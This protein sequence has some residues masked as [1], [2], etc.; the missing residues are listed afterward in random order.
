MRITTDL[1]ESLRKGFSKRF[2]DA[3][4]A[5]TP[6]YEQFASVMPSNTKTNVHGFID[7]IPKMREWV[8]ERVIKNFAE[9]S[10]EI[11]NK[12][13]ELTIGVKRD[14]I[15]DDNLGTYSP[16]FDLMG[17]QARMYPDDL[18]LDLIEAGT[19]RE[20]YDG[21]YFFDTDH[22]KNL[23]DAGA[24]TQSNNF[25]SKAL[26]HD[27]LQSVR[28]AMRKLVGADG[29]T[30]GVN[31]THLVVPPALEKT[32]LQILNAEMVAEGGVSVTNV[33]RGSLKLI[34]W[35]RLTSDTTWYL[36][37]LSKPIKPFVFQ[38][39]STPEF[40]YL[41]EGKDEN[42]FMRDEYLYGIRARGNAGYALWFLAARA[43][44]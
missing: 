28:T 33:L 21:Q 25:T 42:V 10:Y 40:Q 14:D 27:N 23:D 29:R 11:E 1:L 8:G 30:L 4:S 22:P 15:E 7:R 17:Q 19:S 31:P 37:D 32:A 13:H 6:M 2:Q 20:C 26:S 44:A 36:L 5:Q 43:I 38:N 18:V 16:L 34:V 39:R 41:T 35:D 12:K 3:F 9:R 24:G